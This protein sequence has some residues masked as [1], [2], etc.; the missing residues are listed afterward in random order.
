MVRDGL[1]V[2]TTIGTLLFESAPGR[3]VSTED[4]LTLFS[5]GESREV[6]TTQARQF[7]SNLNPFTVDRVLSG[8]SQG[9]TKCLCR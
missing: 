4:C 7:D 5:H 9:G 3:K 1:D 2:I 8:K 6:L